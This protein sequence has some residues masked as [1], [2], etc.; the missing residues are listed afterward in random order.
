MNIHIYNICVYVYVFD[1]M[2]IIWF[3]LVCLDFMANQ[4]FKAI[5]RQIQFH[6]NGQF[7]FN[8]TVKHDYTV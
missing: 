1:D 7:Y 4:S 6:I 2:H 5:E 3:C 8:K